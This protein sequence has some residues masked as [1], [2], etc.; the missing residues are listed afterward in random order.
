MMVKIIAVLAPALLLIGTVGLLL[1]EFIFDWGRTAT[2]TL[3]VFNIVGI[4]LLISV[5]WFNRNLNE[6]KSM[7]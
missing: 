3:A 7:Q 5:N 6:N 2:I 1:N 4:V